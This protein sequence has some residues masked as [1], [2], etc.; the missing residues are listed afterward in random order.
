MINSID[1]LSYLEDKKKTCQCHKIISIFI[2][3]VVKI[4]IGV[5]LSMQCGMR[6]ESERNPNGS[7]EIKRQCEWNANQAN[8]CVEIYDASKC[9]FVRSTEFKTNEQCLDLKTSIV[10]HFK[11]RLKPSYFKYLSH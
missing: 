11:N 10:C 3:R 8:R 9:R 1:K 4:F 2:I 7:N 6:I 5:I